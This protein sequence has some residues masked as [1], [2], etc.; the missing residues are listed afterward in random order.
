M[1]AILSC[2]SCLS[3]ATILESA[4]SFANNVTEIFRKTDCKRSKCPRCKGSGLHMD[5]FTEKSPYSNEPCWFCEGMGVMSVAGTDGYML[6]RSN[7][8]LNT[9]C[10]EMP[11]NLHLYNGKYP[12]SKTKLVA[13]KP[14]KDIFQELQVPF[15]TLDSQRNLT[16]YTASSDTSFSESLK[17]DLTGCDEFTSWTFIRPEHLKKQHY[18]RFRARLNLP[19][20]DSKAVVVTSSLESERT[21]TA[22]LGES[23]VLAPRISGMTQLDESDCVPCDASLETFLK[24]DFW[25]NTGNLQ[26]KDVQNSYNAALVS[27][28]PQTNSLSTRRAS[29][30]SR[31]WGNDE[32]ALEATAPARLDPDS[33]DYREFQEEKEA[34]AV[35]SSI[36]WLS[37]PRSLRKPRNRVREEAEIQAKTRAVRAL[38]TQIVEASSISL[39]PLVDSLLNDQNEEDGYEDLMGLQSKK[40]RSLLSWPLVSSNR[41]DLSLMNTFLCEKAKDA[42]IYNSSSTKP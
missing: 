20:T 6:G 29:R 25:S 10:F 14:P 22:V 3:F 32:N 9:R 42:M 38:I 33:R 18:H 23:S 19:S 21:T 35:K 7:P 31:A 39:D 30:T 11:A 28:F 34:E 36:K 5:L 12:S 13:Y 17:P 15:Y 27:E 16:K 41:P 4:R 37:Q 40:T 8:V 2:A 26:I 1:L 24:E